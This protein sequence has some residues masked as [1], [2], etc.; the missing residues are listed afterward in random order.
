[1]QSVSLY[2]ILSKVIPGSMTFFLLGIYRFTAHEK[3]GDVMA[4]FI[5]YL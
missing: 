5:V 4:L 2:D 1:M 3:I